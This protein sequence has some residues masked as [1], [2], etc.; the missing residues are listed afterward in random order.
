MADE[1]VLDQQAGPQGEVVI[2]C[3][4][5]IDISNVSR[6]RAALLDAPASSPVVVDLNAVDYIDSAG[7]AALFERAKKGTLQVVAGPDCPVRRVLEV[8]ALDQLATIVPTRS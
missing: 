4:G 7:V 5:D 1:F 6:F 8:V 2:V 3:R